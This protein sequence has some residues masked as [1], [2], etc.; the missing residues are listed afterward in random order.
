MLKLLYLV[1]D[2]RLGYLAQTR[3]ALRRS[4]TCISDRYYQDMFVDPLR[5]GY[6][7]PMLFVQALEPL[8]P[9]PDLIFILT[10]PAHVIRSRKDE[11]P[12]AERG[13][14][15][16]AYRALAARYPEAT[17]LDGTRSPGTLARQA[18]M[19]IARNTRGEVK[20]RV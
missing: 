7:A 15:L 16:E 18:R 12:E 9:R 6:T 19:L 13:R 4:T 11:I 8:V 3:P 14:Q 10:A 5:Y 2:F 17:V 20:R 1:A